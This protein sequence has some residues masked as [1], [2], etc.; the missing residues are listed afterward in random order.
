MKMLH[1]LAE[2][3]VALKEEAKISAHGALLAIGAI[4]RMCGPDPTVDSS[5]GLKD[6]DEAIGHVMLSCA[7]VPGVVE[8]HVAPLD[9]SLLLLICCFCY[10]CVCVDRPMGRSGCDSTSQPFAYCSRLCYMV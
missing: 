5:D 8:G 6:V 10:C 9:T 7:C 2:G 3:E 4:K 1:A